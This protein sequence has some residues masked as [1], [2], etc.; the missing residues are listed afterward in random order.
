MTTPTIKVEFT[1]NQLAWLNKQFPELTGN[2]NT[3]SEERAWRA[4]QRSVLL[5][6]Q[7]RVAGKPGDLSGIIQ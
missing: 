5:E 1:R 7:N 4:A 2:H 3:S 6:V